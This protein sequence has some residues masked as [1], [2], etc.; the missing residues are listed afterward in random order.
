[1]GWIKKNKNKIII[2]LVETLQKFNLKLKIK[3]R[4]WNYSY[5][6]KIPS[7]ARQYIII[8]YNVNPKNIKDVNVVGSFNSTLLFPFCASTVL[9]YFLSK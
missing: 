4:P 8:L 1:M 9:K 2:K 3:P 7:E 5:S 6:D